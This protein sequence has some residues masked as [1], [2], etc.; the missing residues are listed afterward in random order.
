MLVLPAVHMSSLTDI[1]GEIGPRMKSGISIKVR[2]KN[3][4]IFI[5]STASFHFVPLISW[6][7]VKVENS[8]LKVIE[9]M[10]QLIQVKFAIPRR[11]QVHILSTI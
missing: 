4:K 3:R 2:K 10:K 7:F 8:H 11:Q 6:K 5:V 1:S 9:T